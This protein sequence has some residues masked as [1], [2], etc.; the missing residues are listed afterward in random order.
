MGHLA[1]E[2]RVPPGELLRAL[3]SCDSFTLLEDHKQRGPRSKL[4]GHFQVKKIGKMLKKYLIG[5]FAVLGILG[6]VDSEKIWGTNLSFSG[7]QF[8]TENVWINLPIGGKGQFL[9]NGQHFKKKVRHK[10]GVEYSR[11]H[12]YFAVPGDPFLEDLLSKLNYSHVA[13]AFRNIKQATH[14]PPQLQAGY[15]NQAIK[16]CIFTLERFVNHPKALIYLEYTARVL[17]NQNLPKNYYLRALSLYPT[18]AFTQAQFG[19]FLLNI[20]EVSES[21][22]RL[23]IAVRLDPKLDIAHGWLALA[24]DMEGNNELANEMAQKAK[25]L[26]YKG[27][28]P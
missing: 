1:A 10:P 21:V 25:N 8:W 9:L 14:A 19:K 15:F 23:K 11:D 24:Y 2:Q 18:R 6:C 13:A 17:G 3:S 20:G 7:Y 16:E 26:G 28:L 4:T 27:Q 22:E 5:V 12:D